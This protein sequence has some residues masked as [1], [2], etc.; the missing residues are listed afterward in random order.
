MDKDFNQI[1]SDS[2]TDETC[3]AICLEEMPPHTAYI[4]ECSHKLH[5][6]CFHEYFKYN[7]DPENNHICCP[8][9]RQ[10]LA[11]SIDDTSVLVVEN[12]WPN[13]DLC[14]NMGFRVFSVTMILYMYF[15][16]VYFF[17]R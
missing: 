4:F 14:V 7:Y 8:V 5:H 12:N 2:S 3:C 10:N 17:F 11:V 16:S 15:I 1:L 9:C 13:H 6:Q